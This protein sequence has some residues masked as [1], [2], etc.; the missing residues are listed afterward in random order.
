MLIYVYCLGQSQNPDVNETPDGPPS[1]ECWVYPYCGESPPFTAA[2]SGTGPWPL[3]RKE[4][5]V[6]GQSK[7]PDGPKDV[8]GPDFGHKGNLRNPQ[9]LKG[10]P[11]PIFKTG[12]FLAYIFARIWLLP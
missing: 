1:H 2:I 7:G 9:D 4:A 12:E 11:L 6:S 3:G 5:C 8:S 10:N